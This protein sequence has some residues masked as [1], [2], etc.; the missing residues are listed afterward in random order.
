MNIRGKS[1]ILFNHGWTQMDTDSKKWTDRSPWPNCYWK[2]VFI[3]V[4]LYPSVVKNPFSIFRQVDE[5][6]QQLQSDALAFFGVE[7]RGVDIVA[8]DR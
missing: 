8:P 7:L 1:E 4:H 2:S 6:L 5:V 3:R